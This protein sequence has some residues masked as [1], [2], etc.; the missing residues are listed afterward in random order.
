MIDCPVCRS[1]D[2]EHVRW[3]TVAEVAE[4]RNA[5]PH[6]VRAAIK[7]GDLPAKRVGRVFIVTVAEAD[8]WT[9]ARPGRP[10]A[11]LGES[12]SPEPGVRLSENAHR[13][14]KDLRRLAARA[15]NSYVG[16]NWPDMESMHRDGIG[17]GLNDREKEAAI[18]RYLY[19]FQP[20]FM[21]QVLD[22]VL[23]A[24]LPAPALSPEP[25]ASAVPTETPRFPG[26]TDGG[27][28][29]EPLPASAVPEP[30]DGLTGEVFNV[31][32]GTR[33]TI[34]VELDPTLDAGA[35]WDQ[36][37]GKNVTI[38]LA[39]TPPGPHTEETR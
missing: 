3:L 24:S 34:A 17:F 9:P 21:L 15:Q 26:G 31:I 22:T 27:I 38:R 13:H 36:W 8:A 32:G 10:R 25:E 14:L 7:A 35:L 18:R 16:R 19:E 20:E 5:H 33:V 29:I 4:R 37:S 39:A 11:A 6:T 12:V 30:T 2:V 1:G 28:T 23:A